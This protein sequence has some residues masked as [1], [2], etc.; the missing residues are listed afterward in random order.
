[1][2]G[3]V[4]PLIFKMPYFP[5]LFIP[6]SSLLH[7]QAIFILM[8]PSPS[9]PYML[10]ALTHTRFSRIRRSSM[11]SDDS[12]SELQSTNAKYV[13]SMFITGRWGNSRAKKSRRR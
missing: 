9:L 4:N 10:P 7:G 5:I 2:Y 3:I 8:K 12:P 1:M 6:S 11:C 13:P